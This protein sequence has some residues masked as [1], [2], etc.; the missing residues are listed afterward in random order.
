MHEKPHFGQV[1]PLKNGK[2][3]AKSLRIDHLRMADGGF[4]LVQKKWI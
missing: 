1:K 2:N 3:R 4:W